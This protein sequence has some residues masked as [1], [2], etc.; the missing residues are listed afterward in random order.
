MRDGCE[1]SR[2]ARLTLRFDPSTRWSTLS[3][4][5]APR[6]DRFWPSETRVQWQRRNRQQGGS[7]ASSRAPASNRFAARS[8]GVDQELLK[9]M[10]ERAKIALEIGKLKDSRR[11]CSAYRPGREDEVLSRVL[12]ANKGPLAERCVRAV[13]RE[14]ISGSRAAGN[15]PAGGL[16][17]PGLQLQP[18]G[19][20]CTASARASNWCR[21]AASPPCSRRSTAARPTSAWCRS[22]TRPTAASPT[23][24]TCSPGCRCSICGEVQLRIHH[25]LLGT[26]RAIGDR[27]GLQQ[28]AGPVAVPQLA[29]QAPAAARTIEV[30]STSTAAQLAQDKPGAAAIASLQAGVHYGL[31]VLAAEHRGQP[32]NITRFAVIG[33]GTAPRTRQ[34]QDGADVRDRASARARWPTR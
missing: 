27:R 25:N 18:S 29:G 2:V 5:P 12:A 10:N 26:C 8:I 6:E 14:L 23:R 28:A 13:F 21:S 33:D 17:G 7:A 34:R 9:L 20:D 32:G 16:S 1:A 24:S 22:K 11:A 19:G 3:P 30:T 15:R 4:T 31:D